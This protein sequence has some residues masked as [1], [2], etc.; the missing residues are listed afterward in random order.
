MLINEK[1]RVC[2]FREIVTIGFVVFFIS[3]VFSQSY[4]AKDSVRIYK[5]L[6]RSDEEAV[7]GSL[8]TAIKY[9]RLALQVSKEKKMLRGEGFAKL[10]IADI[11]LQQESPLDIKDYLDE[12][13]KIGTQLKDS[14][15]MALTAYQQGQ[16]SMYNDQLEE[17]EK[18][19][20]QSLSLKFEK[21][22]SAYTA[23]V[24]NDMG[25]LFGQKD[26]LEKQVE[27]YLK[28]VRLYQKTEDLLGLAT[29]TNNLAA[30]YTKLGNHAKALEYAREAVMM[31]EKIGDVQGLASSYENLSRLYWAISLDS[32]S[33]YQQ[34]AM[35]YAEKSGVKS[36]MIR[37][38]DNLSVLMDR[39]RNK[40]GALS[41][42]KRSIALCREMN[43]KAGLAGKCRWAA[44]LC[45]DMKDTVA[46]E[47]F[48]SESLDLSVQLNNKTL[49]R[50]LY[51]SK[52]GYYS[53]V[54]DFK[55]AYESL[56]KYYAYRD[57]L[58]SD[59]TAT[60]IAELE[61]KYETEK[62][63][64]EITRLNSDQ[65]IKQLQIE[66][67]NALLA[68]N[69]LE[70]QKKEN[71]IEL[72]SGAKELQE[73]KIRQQDEQL[74]KQ[75]LQA[76]NNEQ[77]LQLAEKETQLQQ[78]QLKN[79]ALLRNFMLAAVVLLSLLGYCM[80][81]RYQLKRKIQEQEAL[82]SVRNNIAKD[83]HDEIG[84]TLTS[85]KI[86]SEVSGKNLYK[87]Q[88]KTSSFLQKIT[89]Q[90]AAVQQGISDIVWSVKPENDRL[91]NMVIRMREYVAQTLESKS[92]QTVIHIDEQV[93]NKTLDM[94]QR[95][96][97]FLIFKEAVNNIAKYANATEVQVR[98]EK[99]K[100]DLCM[101]IADNGKGFEVS[102]ETSSSGLKNMKA[103]ALALKGTLDIFSGNGEGS[104]VILTIPAT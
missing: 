55:N 85:I 88:G 16:Q 77:Q 23:L 41:Y 38:Y 46:M 87:D 65:K 72:L 5:W 53:K 7:T 57:S 78:K 75:M 52:A 36:L 62:K 17:A 39:Q 19:F 3:P 103:R 82:L 104:K 11:L 6:N 24:Y 49:L 21:E 74:E 43:D 93:L 13:N 33:K 71:E 14:F 4:T 69:L 30:V 48:Y 25:Y 76:K 20:K 12:A 9:A 54:N 101:M 73:L 29:T 8:D 34:V 89:E 90:S 47:A 70:A 10:K 66:K 91:E 83:L 50:D 2:L 35:K 44:L 102:G 100:G 67:Q 58:V 94:N 68:G 80:F 56:K 37:S 18:L 60:N 79:S 63:D 42:I 22:Q 64:N 45:G 97:F 27:W 98:L 32:A 96:D 92:I 99:K 86:L 26:E 51:G 1:L 84:S 95:R 28:A 61:T 15:M 59:E 40:P 31:R 81:N